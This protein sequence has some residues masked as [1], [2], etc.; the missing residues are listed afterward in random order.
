MSYFETLPLEDIVNILNN[1]DYR[2]I[3]NLSETSS[4]FR[5]LIKNNTIVQ[6]IFYNKIEENLAG[7]VQFSPETNSGYIKIVMNDELSN[8][9]YHILIEMNFSIEDLH[10][11]I[12]MLE[13]ESVTGFRRVPFGDGKLLQFRKNGGLFYKNTVS[14]PSI[15]IKLNK[16]LFVRLLREYEVF[17]RTRTGG[18]VLIRND[19]SVDKILDSLT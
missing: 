2:S 11:I 12:L 9:S 4:E 19:R 3:V 5:D 16:I 17:L 10:R 8:Q 6:D 14:N 18:S 13:S 7:S 1:M 15:S